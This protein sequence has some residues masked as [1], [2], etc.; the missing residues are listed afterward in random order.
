MEDMA[1]K[2]KV[3]ELK[4]PDRVDGYP[5][6]TPIWLRRFLEIVPGL[7]AWFFILSPLIFTLMGWEKVL[8]FYISFLII[9]WVYRGIKFVIGIGIGVHRMH[10]AQ[11]TDFISK[12]KEVNEEEFN[13]INYIY[14][15]PVY[16]EGMDVLDPSFK[17][18][19]KSDVGA[20]KIHVVVAMEERT[21]EDIQIPNFEI[22][23]KRYGIKMVYI[24]EKINLH[25]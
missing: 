3:E 23:K 9:Y 20:N 8:V 15:C 11:A 6:Q 16:K 5:V 22:L 17:A 14:L 25:I 12:I 18:W 21:A 1:K 7:L 19:S 4:A 10:E 2:V 13:K 24:I